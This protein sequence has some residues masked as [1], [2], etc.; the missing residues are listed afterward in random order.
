MSFI[1]FLLSI[2][3]FN[4]TNINKKN[5]NNTLNGNSS[6][7]INN[8]NVPPPQHTPT[9]QQQAAT[10]TT[11]L[12]AAIFVSSNI[13]RPG[14]SRIRFSIH[15]DNICRFSRHFTLEHNDRFDIH[16]FMESVLGIWIWNT[17]EQRKENTNQREFT[18]RKGD[19]QITK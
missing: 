5:N 17:H 3:T 8:S 12:A 6:N 18:P 19:H 16:S 4:S 1:S 11:T 9:T 15:V 14:L 10:T 2:L 7:I 13:T